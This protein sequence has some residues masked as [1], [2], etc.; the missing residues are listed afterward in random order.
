MVPTLEVGDRILV[1]RRNGDPR[2]G[3]IVV[4]HPLRC[5]ESSRSMRRAAADHAGVPSRQGRARA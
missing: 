2:I 5:G 3:D 4:F 1:D